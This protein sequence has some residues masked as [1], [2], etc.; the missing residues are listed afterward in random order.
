MKLPYA[1]NE[2]ERF[3]MKKGLIMFLAF[4]LLFINN[5]SAHSVLKS[6]NPED[7][8]VVKTD[9]TEVVMT[10]ESKIEEGSKLLLVSETG[11]SIPVTVSV[12]ENELIAKMDEPLQAGN[13]SVIWEAASTDGHLLSG[14]FSFEVSADETGTTNEETSEYNADQKQETDTTVEDNATQEQSSQSDVAEQKA[15]NPYLIYGIIGVLIIAII[16]G[17]RF[18]KK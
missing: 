2:R 18:L 13:Y 4:F 7:G 8:E 6:T 16:F 17:I 15:T 3:A 5:V 14:T 9:L 10:F 1:D 11:A 12:T